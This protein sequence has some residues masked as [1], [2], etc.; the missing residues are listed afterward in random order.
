MKLCGRLLAFLSISVSLSSAITTPSQAAEASAGGAKAPAKS[1]TALSAVSKTAPVVKTATPHPV[2]AATPAAKPAPAEE[3]PTFAD[4]KAK[5]EF[6]TTLANGIA[7]FKKNKQEEALVQFQKSRDLYKNGTGKENSGV[8]NWVG[9]TQQRLNKWPDAQVTYEKVVELDSDYPEARN[10]LAYT[11]QK[12][13]VLDKA[14]TEY[15]KAIQLKPDFLVAHYNLAKVF[16]LEKKFDEALIQYEKV[17]ELKPND[18]MSSDAIYQIGNISFDKKDYDK[19]S[20]FYKKALEKNAKNPAVLSKLARI[21]YERGDKQKAMDQFNS[22]IDLNPQF[23]ESLLW[24]GKGSIDG[25]RLNEAMG[26]YGKALEVNPYD[27]EIHFELGKLFFTLEQYNNSIKQ[28]QDTLRCESSYPE[29]QAWLDK[30]V[31]KKKS[32]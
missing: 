19:A 32:F 27:P 23:Y 30:V 22:V 25:K 2:A 18:N 11:Y 10:N 3:E 24:L 28:F 14:E 17:L 7:L 13:N 8:L 21:E 20:E 12:L 9:V 31:A 6:E 15:L 16:L 29:A 5:D 4:V 26:F 1:N